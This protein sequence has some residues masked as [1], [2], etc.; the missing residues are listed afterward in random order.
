MT[1][2]GYQVEPAIT[3]PENARSVTIN[4]EGTVEVLL[5][6]TTT[7]T[8]VGQIQL[9]RF[10]NKGGLQSIGENLFLETPASGS[11]TQGT[12][13]DAGYGDLLQ[14]FL[15]ASNVNAVAEL[16]DLIP[17]SAPMK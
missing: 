1:L 11:P 4:K 8:Q 10:V 14:K 7:P 9:T 17:R 5:D 6:N 13:G 15:E 12:P 2:D 16:S 3:I